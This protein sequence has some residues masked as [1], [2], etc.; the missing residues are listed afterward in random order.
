VTGV[1]Q[2]SL[3]DSQLLRNVD[4]AMNGRANFSAPA[5]GAFREVVVARDINGR[6]I[7]VR[8]RGARLAEAVVARAMNSRGSLN[9]LVCDDKQSQSIVICQYLR[10]ALY[11]EVWSV[12]FD[13]FGGCGQSRLVGS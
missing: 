8:R 13:R 9:K 10:D 1:T 7:Q 11:K 3:R 5:R 12:G 4:P 6:L 2:S